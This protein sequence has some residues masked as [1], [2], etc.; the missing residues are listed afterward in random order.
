MKA[1]FRALILAAVGA[2]ALSASAVAQGA[3]DQALA[4]ANRGD[5]AT[6]L[7]LW[8]PLAE[9]GDADA[10]FRL[11]LLYH[12]GEGVPQN[13]VAAVRW[14]HLAAEQDVADAQTN[15]GYMY[16]MGEGVPKNDAEAVHWSGLAAEQGN[17]DAQTNLGVMYDKG[18]GVPENDVEAYKWWALAAAQGHAGAKKYRDSLRDEMTTAEIAEGQ[19]LAAEW[20]PKESLK[21]WILQYLKKEVD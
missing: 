11:G 9:Q 14:Y 13:F 18:R 10:Q 1:T 2:V 15:L 8:H 5:Y 20:K 7:R 21:D 16:Y 3:S 17:A 4:A 12:R 6:A 19:W